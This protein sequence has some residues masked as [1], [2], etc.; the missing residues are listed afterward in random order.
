M[1]NIFV[2]NLAVTTTEE[3]LKHTFEPFGK[4]LS[5]KVVMDRDTGTPRGFAFIEMG[6]DDEAQRAIAATDGMTLDERRLTVNAARPKDIS[7]GTAQP[8]MR[9]HRQHRY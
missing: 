5:V 8:G 2:G 1:Q 3:T 4:V 7:T 9:R 6:S